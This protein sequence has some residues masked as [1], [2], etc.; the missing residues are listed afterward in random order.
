QQSVERSMIDRNA[1][2]NVLEIVLAYWRSQ[3]AQT[4]LRQGVNES[5]RQLGISIRVVLFKRCDHEFNKVCPALVFGRRCG[6]RHLFKI[7]CQRQPKRHLAASGWAL[8]T[9]AR[10]LLKHANGSNSL[11]G[12]SGQLDILPRSIK[13]VQGAMLRKIDEL[14]R[15]APE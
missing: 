5:N 12:A 10:I 13:L 8:Q 6:I 11:V 1:C 7:G 14:V 9:E 4:F 15:L 2:S 3:E